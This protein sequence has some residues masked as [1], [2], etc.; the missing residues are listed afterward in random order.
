MS[1]TWD[2]S[3]LYAG[4]NDGRI[5]ADLTAAYEAAVTFAE[6]HRGGVATLDAPA[7]AAAITAYEELEELGRRP[8]FYAHLLFAADTQHD[9]ARRL[10]DRT[11]EASVALA[12][13]LTFFELELKA[14]A[15]DACARLTADPILAGRRHWLGLLR[16]RRP[17]TLSEPEERIVN[18]KNLTGRGAL[19]QL[20][21]EL[22]GSLRFHVDGRE[23]TDE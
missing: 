3:S 9:G 14:I 4:T 16:R 20:F 21:D 22:S 6:R 12:N 18:Q 5:E 23:M 8:G 15:D 11:R 7:L 19:V 1:I 17:Y 2:L 13:V 10:V